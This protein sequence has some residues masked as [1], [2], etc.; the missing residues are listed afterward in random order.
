MDQKDFQLRQKIKAAIF[1]LSFFSIAGLLIHSLLSTDDMTHEN[2]L[3]ENGKYIL[4]SLSVLIIWNFALSYFNKLTLGQ[5]LFYSAVIEAP[6]Q[7]YLEPWKWQLLILTVTVVAGSAHVSGVS[8]LE[9]FN[10]DGFRGAKDLSKGLLSPDFSLIPIATVKLGETLAIAFI[11]TFLSLPLAAAIAFMSAKNLANSPIRFSVYVLVRIG[12]NF[13]RSIEPVIWAVIFA[14]WVG[15]GPF[16]G[17]LALFVQSIASLA[18][19]FSEAIESTSQG[20]IEGI[21]ST[22]ATR[23]QTIWLGI[24]PQVTMPFLSFTLYRWDTNVRMATIIGMAGG[25]GIGTLLYQYS[26]RAQWPQVGCLIL[27]IAITVALLDLLSAY[28]REALK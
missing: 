2:I 13:M 16:A 18:K 10:P 23:F 27:V 25:G 7:W 15:I 6:K 12:L 28:V 11:A 21:M 26:M 5:K 24:I 19:Q 14:V 22:G 8:L 17:M 1:D 9:L 3:Q 20:P 4:L